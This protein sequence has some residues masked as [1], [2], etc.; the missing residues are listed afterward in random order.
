MQRVLVG[1]SS[2]E[3]KGASLHTSAS[4][5]ED[6]DADVHK[7]QANG[8]HTPEA[9]GAHEPD[10]A[11]HDGAWAP[12]PAGITVRSFIRT[13]VGSQSLKQRLE[14]LRHR[15]H[16][17]RWDDAIIHVVR[18]LACCTMTCHLVVSSSSYVSHPQDGELT[19]LVARLETWAQQS[20]HPDETALN[21]AVEAW[22][23]PA[24]VDAWSTI[25]TAEPGL[26]RSLT[27]KRNS[28]LVCARSTH[29]KP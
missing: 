2:S 7:P 11:T 28:S 8:T 21:A 14:A 29:V 23:S 20:V 26:G 24:G 13:A 18:M 25:K 19:F 16:T 3:G 17:G 22:D 9:N 12:P 15:A 10:E 5:T 1:N 27:L 4:G 6:D